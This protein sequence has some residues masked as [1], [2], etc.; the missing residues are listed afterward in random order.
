MKNKLKYLIMAFIMLFALTSCSGQI[1]VIPGDNNN[2]KPNTPGDP[3]NPNNPGDPDNPNT[4]DNPSD[5]SVKYSVTMNY[6]GEPYPGNISNIK[7]IFINKNT[8]ATYQAKFE[9]GAV[10]STTAPEGEY[11]V[12]LSSTPKGYSYDPNITTV[13]PESPASTIELMLNSKLR[14]TTGASLYDPTVINNIS[15]QDPE[16]KG[17]TYCYEATFKEAG[18]SLYFSFNPT[19]YGVYEVESLVDM[20]NGSINPKAQSYSI[21][22]PNSSFP[23]GDLVDDGGSQLKGGYT[24]NFKFQF[25]FTQGHVGGVA[26]FRIDIDV[27]DSS[28]KFPVTIPFKITY[29]DTYSE[30]KTKI[31][32]MFAEDLYA[33]RDELGNV[34]YKTD[35]VGN[36]IYR[37][38]DN[39]N[40]ITAIGKNGETIKLR[41]FELNYVELNDSNTYLSS[42]TGSG[43][44][45]S[46]VDPGNTLGMNGDNESRVLNRRFV[47]N[48]DESYTADIT[49]NYVL[50]PTVKANNFSGYTDFCEYDLFKKN[51]NYS[52]TIGNKNSPYVYYDELDGYY[53]FN[54]GVYNSVVTMS[55]TRTNAILEAAFEGDDGASLGM[56]LSGLDGGETP[57]LPHVNYHNYKR[58]ILSEYVNACND[59]V[60]FANYELSEFMIQLNMKQGFF[61]DGQ[62]SLENIPV[63]STDEAQWL[64][65]CGFYKYGAFLSN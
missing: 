42:F 16:N 7:A 47:K 35:S 56:T 15:I 49:G 60:V 59:G 65:V 29:M 31:K 37:K 19:D 18:K 11:Y 34:I 24:K 17:I 61:W 39:G 26:K 58:F 36:P 41:E 54:D 44:Y 62:G 51:G 53:H 45:N 57:I 63:Y 1:D 12:H 10:A 48:E 20:F 9:S 22:S 6:T 43:W 52:F 46:W 3:D 40:I 2:N 4:P 28:V 13:S 23:E 38:D 64:F 50:E 5:N 8:G 21:G 30:N 14:S 33:K 32:R 55:I 25:K 27:K